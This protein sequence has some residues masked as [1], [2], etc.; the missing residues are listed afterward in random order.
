MG[1]ADWRYAGSYKVNKNGGDIK[2]IDDPILKLKITY[3]KLTDKLFDGTLTRRDKD[4]LI[5]VS[6]AIEASQK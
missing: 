1:K 2:Y 6:R 5:A 4:Q 3:D